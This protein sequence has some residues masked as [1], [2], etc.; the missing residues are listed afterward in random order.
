M[1]LVVVVDLEDRVD[2]V[3]VRGVFAMHDY[4]AKDVLGDA[5]LLAPLVCVVREDE[6]EHAALH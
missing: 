5:A 4:M 3:V 2:P 1:D 6:V